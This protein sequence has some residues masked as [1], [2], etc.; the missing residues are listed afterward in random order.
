MREGSGVS[1]RG[2]DVPRVAARREG[3][4]PGCLGNSP[5]YFSHMHSYS[6]PYPCR[7]VRRPM[8]Q[9]GESSRDLEEG[10]V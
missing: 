5:V 8:Q 7:W 4:V 10:M 6:L 2:R 3:A 9:A 1:S